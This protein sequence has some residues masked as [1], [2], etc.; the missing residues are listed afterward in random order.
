MSKSG[1]KVAVISGASKG[2]G[3]AAAQRFLD[4]G[5]RVINLSRSANPDSRVRN[6]GVD[7]SS[8]DFVQQ[9][10]PVLL[11]QLEGA[12]SICLIHN[13]ALYTRD[14]V[15]NLQAAELATILQVNV[16]ASLQL[17]QLLLPLMN[18]GSSIL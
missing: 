4:A 9:L 6:I 5:Y 12:E 7:L 8:A 11:P 1:N 2:I 18:T 13:A 17:N 14:T 3:A 16:I 15:E 10:R